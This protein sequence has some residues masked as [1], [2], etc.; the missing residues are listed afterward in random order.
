M[1]KELV[2]R[3]HDIVA[4]L[5]DDVALREFEWRILLLVQTVCY[6]CAIIMVLR[7]GTISVVTLPEEVFIEIGCGTSADTEALVVDEVV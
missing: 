7:L 6:L 2:G 3:R 1:H 4:C 5:E